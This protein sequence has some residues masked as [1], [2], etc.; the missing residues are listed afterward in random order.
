[1]AT[2]TGFLLNVAECLSTHKGIHMN[3]LLHLYRR[4][5]RLNAD[6]ALSTLSTLSTSPI[7]DLFA[8]YFHHN[9]GTSHATPKI[10]LDVIENERSYRVSAAIA[11]AKKDDIQLDIDKNEVSITVEI[12]REAE[13]T[14][15]EQALHRERLFGKT[16]RTF[17]LAEEIDEANVEAKYADGVLELTLPKKTPVNA[18]RIAIN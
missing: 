5:N 6:R 18:K 14:E 7:D 1:M 13:A 16:S 8:G 9:T 2:K 4:N 15:G 17:T 10:R 11:G 12:K 3:A